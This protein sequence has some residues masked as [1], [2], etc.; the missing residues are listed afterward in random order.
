MAKLRL[1]IRRV[2]AGHLAIK[3]YDE[4][5]FDSH[6]YINQGNIGNDSSKSL[7]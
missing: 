7:F 1:Q 3:L 5:N 6:D 2:Q 4:D